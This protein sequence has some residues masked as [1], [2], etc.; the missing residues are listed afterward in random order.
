MK[1]FLFPNFTV[2]FTAFLL[3]FNA[4]IFPVAEML[5]TFLFEVVYLTFFPV[6][7]FTVSFNCNVLPFFKVIVLPVLTVFLPAFN[8]N[9][10]TGLLTLLSSFCHHYLFQLSSVSLI[11]PLKGYCSCIQIFSDQ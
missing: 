9:F 1:L 3:F 11:L 10:C 4:L 5:T 8:D 2:I 7:P 6:T